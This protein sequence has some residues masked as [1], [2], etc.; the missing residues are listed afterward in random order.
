MNKD[1]L[2]TLQ[3]KTKTGPFFIWT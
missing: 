1:V 3:V 2:Y